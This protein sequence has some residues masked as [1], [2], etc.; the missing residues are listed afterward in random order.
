VAGTLAVVPTFAVGAVAVPVP[1][2]SVD[3]LGCVLESP[4]SARATPAKVA[5]AVPIPSAT[6]KAPMRPT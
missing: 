1:P 4:V 2:V 3:E 6:A 5:T